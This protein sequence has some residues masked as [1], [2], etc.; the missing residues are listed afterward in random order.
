[1]IQFLVGLL[2]THSPLSLAD[3]MTPRGLN[4]FTKEKER[5]KRENYITAA[6]VKNHYARKMLFR[7]FLSVSVLL[8]RNGIVMRKH[9]LGYI[10]CRHVNNALFTVM[11]LITDLV[12]I[13]YTWKKRFVMP[14]TL[15]ICRLISTPDLWIDP[16]DWFSMVPCLNHFFF[17]P[18]LQFG[19]M[20]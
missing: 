20:K 19:K 5:P 18:S 2:Q 14:P 3:A 8:T 15:Y 9:K 11:H 6:H 12:G 13:S 17:P 7:I 10:V 1:M 4:R 16:P